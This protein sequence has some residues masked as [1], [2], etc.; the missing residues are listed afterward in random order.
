MEKE[1]VII[2]SL[3]FICATT[4]LCKVSHDYTERTKAA[5]MAG[6][7]ESVGRAQGAWIKVK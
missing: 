7:E 3:F 6:Y 5:F 4:L 2:W 1:L